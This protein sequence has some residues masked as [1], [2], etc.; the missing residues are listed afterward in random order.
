M[1]R[2]RA[3]AAVLTAVL[4]LC[5]VLLL[6]PAVPAHGHPDRA[7]AGLARDSLRAALTRDLRDDNPGAPE[8]ELLPR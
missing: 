5:A 7:T 1:S 2:S 8:S 6:A 3:R 4:C